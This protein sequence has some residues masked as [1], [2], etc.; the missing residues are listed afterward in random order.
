[1]SRFHKSAQSG[2]TLI[3][4][5]V[6]LALIT[7]LAVGIALSFNGARS[8]AQTL[9]QTMSELASANVRLKNDTGCYADQPVL[10]IDSTVAS[11]TAANFCAKSL[12][13]TW[14]GPYVAAFQISG[15]N[16][17]LDKVADGVAVDF[18]QVKSLAGGAFGTA[19]KKYTVSATGVPEDVVKAALQECNGV[20]TDAT[21]YQNGRKCIGTAA[22][23]TFSMLF[24]ETK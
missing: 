5:L 1:M 14:N 2:F 9:L 24:D 19:G 8:R 21:D 3:E 12:V 13:N 22:S 4:I 7:L 18:A 17:D 11:T 20:D 23:G 10:L 16:V 6:A 15:T